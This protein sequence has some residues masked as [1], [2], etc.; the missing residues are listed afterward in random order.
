MKLIKKGEEIWGECEVCGEILPIEYLKL[1]DRAYKCQK[2]LT[3]S[4][5]MA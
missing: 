5:G 3:E 1:T 4:W 2:C